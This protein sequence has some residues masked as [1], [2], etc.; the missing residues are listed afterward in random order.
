MNATEVAQE[1]RSV[2]A[3]VFELSQKLTTA[4]D[5]VR[6]TEIRSPIS[7]VVV[8]MD[9]STIGGVISAGETLL[10]VLPR[11]DAF[12]VQATVDPLDIDRIKQGL[13]ATVFLT[14]LNRR[15]HSGIAATVGTISA[16]RLTD[17]A[18]GEAYYVA[19]IAMDPVEVEQS[20]IQLQAGMGAEV[21]IATGQQTAL[22]YVAAPIARSL[23]RA[24][25]EE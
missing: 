25:R 20:A 18:T 1:L 9:V 7:G 23:S 11:G 21:M 2:G 24:F 17:P 15:T 19:R 22:E 8:N 5:V 12:V 16:D 6:R 14:S 10:S 4:Q 3:Q 13:D